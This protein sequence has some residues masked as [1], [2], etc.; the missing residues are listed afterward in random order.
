[1]P[2]KPKPQHVAVKWYSGGRLYDTTHLCYVS[3]EQLRHWA[4]AGVAFSVID[5]A[6]GTDVKAVMLA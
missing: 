3:I 6:S 2:K 1:M 4:S 5:A